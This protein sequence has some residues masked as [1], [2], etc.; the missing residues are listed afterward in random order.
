M[1]VNVAYETMVDQFGPWLDEV[2][3]LVQA[4]VGIGISDLPDVDFWG[5]YESGLDSAQAAKLLLAE[6]GWEAA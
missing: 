2:D 6:N 4:E 5:W 1:D 3:H